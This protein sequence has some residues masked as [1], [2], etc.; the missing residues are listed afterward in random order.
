MHAALPHYI[1]D[2]V[3]TRNQAAILLYVNAVRLFS[4]G[5]MRGAS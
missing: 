2:S 3:T 4:F 5:A 1:L